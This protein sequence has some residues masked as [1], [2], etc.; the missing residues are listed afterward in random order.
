MKI[1]EM[2]IQKFK[3]FDDL[4]I[5][6]LE[7]AKLVILVGTNGSGKSSVLEACN[8]W[9]KNILI[10]SYNKDYYE[11]CM[12]EKPKIDITFNTND[13]KL[14]ENY[15]RKKLMHFRSAYRNEADFTI[16]QFSKMQDF[17]NKSR[18][19]KMI[20]NDISVSDNFQRLV[21][22]TLSKVYDEA[23]N[24]SKIE[25]IREELIGK[26][27]NSMKNVFDDLILNGINKPLEDGSFYFK[28]G[29]IESFHYKNL[30][31][32]EK[33]AFDLLLDLVLKI[34]YFDDSIIFID[35]PEAHMH[36]SLQSKLIE[37]I[38]H[39]IPEQNQL[40]ITTHS[41]GI[42]QKV[43]ELITVEHQNIAILDFSEQD[44]DESIV[45][46]PSNLDKV[47]WK[48]FLSFTLEDLSNFIAPEVIILC[49]GKLEGKNGKRENF[50]AEIY[51]K[52]FNKKYPNVTFVSQGNCED[53][54]NKEHKGALLLE[55]IL[56][57]TK[58][59]RLIDR[60][61][62]S[63]EEKSENEKEKILVLD[64]TN[65]ETYLLDNE[66]IEKFCED[67][68]LDIN[69]TL[70]EIQKIKDKD[71]SNFK[72]ARGYIY[73]LLK[74]K[75]KENNKDLNIGSNADAFLKTCLYKYVTED[76]KVYQELEGIIF[77]NLKD[78]LKEQ[79]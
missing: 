46:E 76:T 13:G 74:V 77:K 12:N 15:D 38:Y 8:T 65:L 73:T 21:G 29:K 20:D 78:D 60:D 18:V 39:L 70:I 61:T 47:I 42:L 75:L 37:E 25:D 50:D 45:L 16:Q 9:Q 36:T 69:S 4:T 35:E 43:K 1:K 59:L 5:R 54:K 64:R 11:K 10:L 22:M 7:N 48:K 67:K 79:Q 23:N 31:A 49:E 2:R 30:S 55:N 68:G 62:Q 71:R 14:P 66:I 51:N 28:K 33:S 56:P 72:D 32:G 17:H 58:I 34:E 53:L 3:R 24:D 26:I 41:L 52:I 6:G 63:D 44:F 40:W 27:R 57:N 19:R